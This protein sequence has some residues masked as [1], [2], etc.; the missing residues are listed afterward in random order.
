MLHERIEPP[1][2]EEDEKEKDQQEK[3]KIEREKFLQMLPKAFSYNNIVS[4]S[5]K[6]V[7]NV[8]Y[9]DVFNIS[10]HLSIPLQ[11]LIL[12]LFLFSNNNSPLRN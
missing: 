3:E 1:K 2:S 9:I 7:R 4:V 8:L 10:F 5:H 11:L 6:Q 12:S